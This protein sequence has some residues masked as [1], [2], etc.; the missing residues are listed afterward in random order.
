MAASIPLDQQTPERAFRELSLHTVL[1]LSGAVYYECDPQTDAMAWMDG[2]AAMALLDLDDGDRIATGHGYNALL[3]DASRLRRERLLAVG[4]GEGGVMRLEYAVITGGGETLWLEERAA[5]I[6]DGAPRLVGAL[7]SIQRQKRRERA[8]AASAAEDDLTGLLTRPRLREAMEQGFARALRRDDRMAYAALA[9]DD[10]SAMNLRFGFDIAD[11]VIAEIGG[12]LAD[13]VGGFDITGRIAGNKFGIMLSACSP[14]RAEGAIRRLMRAAARDEVMTAIGPV[15]VTLS[16]G[17]VS[18]DPAGADGRRIMM[19]AEAALDMAKRAGPGSLVITDDESPSTTP[20]ANHAQFATAIMR[21]LREDRIVL[22][23]QPIVDA[24][25]GVLDHHEC[26]ARMRDEDG[27]V[28]STAAFIEAAEATGLVRRV[29]TRV[30]ARAMTALQT[31]PDLRVSVNVSGATVR[32]RDA[33]DAYVAMLA[34]LGTGAPRLT[35]ELTESCVVEAH[36]RVNS[37]VKGVKAAGARFSVDDFGAGYTSFRQLQS[38][39]PD[40]VKI[41]GG[42]VQGIAQD[43]QKASFVDALVRL[44]RS[45]DVDV[46]AE[47]VSTP[48]EARVL[49]DLGVDRLQGSLTGMPVTA[50]PDQPPRARL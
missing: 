50:E 34:D 10:L 32:S 39:E 24:R 47:F 26:L 6:D 40:E 37:F 49:R 2:H 4:A 48:E 27:A 43:A 42:F 46:V 3:P 19:R 29:D 13:V 21:A 9:I 14:E 25:S 33:A 18:F 28:A 8:L 30:L 38:L 7:R 31:W 44:A 17:G 1:S 35:V 20:R 12:R 16:A 5:W 22:A 36:E 11:Q 41:D 15:E 23:Y 45:L